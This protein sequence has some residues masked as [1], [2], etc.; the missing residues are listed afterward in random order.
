MKGMHIEVA[1]SLTTNET[2]LNIQEVERQK[3]NKG[4]NAR[5]GMLLPRLSSLEFWLLTMR[6][7]FWA[8]HL[9]CSDGYVKDYNHKFLY[10][11]KQ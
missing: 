10:D 4:T 3:R 5:S 6:I 7:I 8:F 9:F 2:R 1:T 11:R